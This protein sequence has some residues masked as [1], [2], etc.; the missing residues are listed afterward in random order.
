[1]E[2][3][4][5]L[6]LILDGGQAQRMGGADKGLVAA[7]PKRFY[8]PPYIGARGWVGMRLDAKRVDWKEVRELVEASYRSVAPRRLVWC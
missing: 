5:T 1:M 3:K 6:G 8:V 4:S 2:T 7:D